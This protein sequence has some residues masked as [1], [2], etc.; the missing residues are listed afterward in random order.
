MY[1]CGGNTSRLLLVVKQY[2]LT[3]GQPPYIYVTGVFIPS[4]DSCLIAGYQVRDIVSMQICALMMTITFD[5]KLAWRI[6]NNLYTQNQVT[7]LSDI[8]NYQTLVLEALCYVLSGCHL[9]CVLT[10]WVI[11]VTVLMPI[12]EFNFSVKNNSLCLSE[13]S[14]PQIHSCEY[15]DANW[16]LLFQQ[17]NKSFD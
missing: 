7:S 14:Y 5:G 4:C 10:G 16:S 1:V 15:F 2:N 17:L 11:E 9:Q 6:T 8:Y 13:L 3:F 12:L